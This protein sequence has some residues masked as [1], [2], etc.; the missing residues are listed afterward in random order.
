M[1]CRSDP[2]QSSV[3]TQLKSGALPEQSLTAAAQTAT[4]GE[5]VEGITVG[6]G[7]GLT[8]VAPT[9]L[10]GL[11]VLGDFE[12]RVGFGVG[13]FPPGF[14]VGEDTGFEVG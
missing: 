14:N 2:Q 6:L 5:A 1:V 12:M 13:A 3:Q 8:E 11:L 9:R 7:V 4:V 10:I